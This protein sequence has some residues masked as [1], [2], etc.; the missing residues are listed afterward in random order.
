MND[1]SLMTQDELCVLFE[2]TSEKYEK[3]K[4]E[5]SFINNEETKNNIRKKMNDLTTQIQ[6]IVRHCRKKGFY[7]VYLGYEQYSFSKVPKSPNTQKT[8]LC[9]ASSNTSKDALFS[10]EK[11]E[12]EVRKRQRIVKRGNRN[13]R[14]KTKRA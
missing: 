8:P 13:K 7:P 2:K 10:R 12:T 5:I 3:K 6:C 14:R 11:K 9:Q 1:Y 4:R